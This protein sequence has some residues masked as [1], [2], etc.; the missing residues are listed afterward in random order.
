MPAADEAPSPVAQALRDIPWLSAVPAGALAELAAHAMLHRIPGGSRLFEQAET[1]AF[2]QILL[3]GAVEL[4]AVKGRTET[5]VATVRPVDM[6]LPA[7][8]LTRQPFLVSARVLK[9]AAI[10]LVQADAF[11]SA[12][13][14][15]HRLCLAVL[16]CQAA[17]FRGQLRKAKAIHLRSA[18]ERIGCYL[19][20]LAETA[21]GQLIRLPHEKRLIASQLGMTRETLS[22]ALRQ[23]GRHGLRVEGDTLH[24][25]DLTAARAAFPLDPLVDGPEVIT[26]LPIAR[27]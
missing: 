27:N 6:I 2:A 8:V 3:A 21:D 23:M 11:R 15:D 1:P 7:A 22:R 13:A 19:L 14:R 24:V 12:V 26:P 10:L 5:L 25:D 17:Q 20:G 18:D 16:A 4:L 9:E